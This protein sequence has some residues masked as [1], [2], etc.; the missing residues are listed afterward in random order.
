MITFVTFYMA[1]T[2]ERRVR[3]SESTSSFSVADDAACWIDLLFRS[4]RHFHPDCRC[5]LLSDEETILPLL[6][7]V[8]I[9]RRPVFINDPLWSRLMAERDFLS[10]SEND[11]NIAFVDF[12]VLVNG[13]LNDVFLEPFDVALTCRPHPEMPVNAGVVLTRARRRLEALAFFDRL[14]GIYEQHFKGDLWWAD[15]RALALLIGDEG[16]RTPP[17][18]SVETEGIYIRLLPVDEFNYTP[19][20][21]RHLLR[22]ADNVKI[23]H[24]KGNRKPLMRDHWNSHHLRN[25]RPAERHRRREVFARCRLALRAAF[26]R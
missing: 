21:A 3:L 19:D 11:Q 10:D 14:L 1:L 18:P 7:D 8:E 4:A 22:V 20:R 26:N 12:D 15:Q 2:P 16:C 25:E 23:L 5:V 24:F 6:R 13:S 17:P 9:C